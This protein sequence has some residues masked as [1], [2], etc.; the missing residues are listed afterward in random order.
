MTTL[1]ETGKDPPVDDHRRRIHYREQ[2]QLR[3]LCAVGATRA[4][5]RRMQIRGSASRP[6]RGSVAVAV[7]VVMASMLGVPVPVMEVVN[8]V[9]MLDGLMAAALTVDVLV[10]GLLV[11]LVLFVLFGRRHLKVSIYGGR[12]FV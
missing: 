7:L 11:L 12:G 1:S 3:T 4:A 10:I 6:R 8:M 5:L 9:A 2:R